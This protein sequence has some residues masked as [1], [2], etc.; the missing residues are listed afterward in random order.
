MPSPRQFVQRYGFPAHAI[1]QFPNSERAWRIDSDQGPLVLRLHDPD[2]QADYH[3]NHPAEIAVLRYLE[4]IGF[5]APRL[6]PAP[7]GAAITW[8]GKKAGYLTTF[9][10]GRHLVPEMDSA[11][12]L[13]AAIARVHR[14]DCAG[15]PDTNFNVAAKKAV[16]H[17]FDADPRVQA[18]EGYAEIRPKLKGAWEHLPPMT[19]LPPTLIHTDL[20]FRNAVL[21]PAG[22]LVFIDWEGCGVGP[23]IQD[24][25]YFL[26]GYIIPRKY[27]LRP[28]IVRAFLAGY[29]SVRLLSPQEWSHLP[30]AIVFGC[31]FYVLWYS[32]VYQPG[33]RGTCYALDHRDQIEGTL[34]TI[35]AEL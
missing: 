18:W 25:G 7:D 1:T 21:T 31:I 4:R 35:R 19:D 12:Q 8:W 33:W 23:A 29:I 11:R 5:P 28:D 32:M 27:G 6:V 26:A 10:P 24:I 22:H 34:E 9:L 3:A 15:L 13:G 17:R 20:D 2:H 14:L 30:D 16:F